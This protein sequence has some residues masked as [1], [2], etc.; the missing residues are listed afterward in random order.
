MTHSAD[1]I[2]DGTPRRSNHSS[3]GTSAIAITSAAVTGRKNSAP[4]RSANGKATIRPMP[5]VRVSDASSR[6]RLMVMPSASARA[7]RRWG[8]GPYACWSERP[9]PPPYLRRHGEASGL[10]QPPARLLTSASIDDRPVRFSRSPAAGRRRIPSGCSSTRCRAR[11][12]SRCRSCSRRP[13]LPTSRTASRS[14]RTAPGARNILALNPNGKI[15][16]ILDPDGPGGQPLALFESGAILLYLAGKTGQLLAGIRCA[17][18]KPS[19]GCSGRWA[20]S[21]RCSARSAISTASTARRSRT[22]GR[23]SIM[24]RRAGACSAC[25]TRRLDRAANG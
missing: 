5:A 17:G 24:S 11:T 8:P 22:R 9:W 6:S 7:R 3:S 2:R 18:G 1:A 15:P 25:S 13:G 14:A 16:A 19:S 10:L 12:G 23:S 4:A 21:G 20:G